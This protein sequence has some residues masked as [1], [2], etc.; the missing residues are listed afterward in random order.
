MSDY[1]SW[2]EALLDLTVLQNP[3]N[4][5]YPPSAKQALGLVA[6]EKVIFYGGAGGG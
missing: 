1:Q 6:P 5:P 2:Y 4:P 3:F